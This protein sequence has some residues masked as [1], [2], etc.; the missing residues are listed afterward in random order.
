MLLLRKGRLASG[1]EGEA[2]CWLEPQVS[3]ECAERLTGL[4]ASL[5]G[6]PWS[7]LNLSAGVASLPRPSWVPLSSVGAFLR[8]LTGRELPL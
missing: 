3:E 7:P 4:P 8:D 2:A 6:G 5:I 1:S